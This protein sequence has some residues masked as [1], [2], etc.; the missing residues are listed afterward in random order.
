[1][2]SGRRKEGGG[3]ERASRKE[4]KFAVF[5]YME[6]EKRVASGRKKKRVASGR[7]AG[8]RQKTVGRKDRWWGKKRQRRWV[9]S[10]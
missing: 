10:G 4:R 1:M 2:G 5:R 7:E 9:K 8:I 6:G 3:E